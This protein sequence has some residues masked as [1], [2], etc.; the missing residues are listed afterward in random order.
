[1]GSVMRPSSSKGARIFSVG[2]LAALMV[3]VVQSKQIYDSQATSQGLGQVS[4]TV[5]SFGVGDDA[6]SGSTHIALNPSDPMPSLQGV[7]GDVLLVS[8]GTNRLFRHQGIG[9]VMDLSLSVS[10]PTE[11]SVTAIPVPESGVLSLPVS[12]SPESSSTAIAV[13]EPGVLSLLGLGL[14]GLVIAR[15][16]KH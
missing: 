6:I 16:R 8:D 3:G 1:M 9:P 14:A 13:P 5:S 15:R 2:V 4:R 12:Q 11:P 10:K 7:L